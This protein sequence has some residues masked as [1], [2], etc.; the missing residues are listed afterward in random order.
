MH[1][2]FYHE[3]VSY[4]EVQ[5]VFSLLILFAISKTT[6]YPLRPPSNC[7]NMI[8]RS[9]PMKSFSLLGTSLIMSSKSSQNYLLISSLKPT[10]EA[11]ALMTFKIKSPKINLIMMILSPCLLTATTSFL[12]LLSIKMPTPFL[13][14][15]FHVYHNLKYSPPP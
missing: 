5:D 15:S 3:V 14:R 4:N 13:L 12:R 2:P 8:L 10:C 7:A 1:L 9:P 6:M 11:Y